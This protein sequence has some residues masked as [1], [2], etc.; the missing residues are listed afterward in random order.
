MGTRKDWDD[1]VARLQR[2]GRPR[3][4]LPD[5]SAHRAVYVH[6]PP[7]SGLQGRARRAD[8][9][10]AVADAA[11]VAAHNAS[12]D[13]S[14]LHAQHP[15]AEG[16]QRTT[17]TPTGVRPAA[18]PAGSVSTRRTARSSSESESPRSSPTKIAATLQHVLV[19][20]AVVVVV[21]FLLLVVVLAIVVC[22]APLPVVSPLRRPAVKVTAARTRSQ[23][24]QRCTAAVE[25]DRPPQLVSRPL[26]VLAL[27]GAAGH[28]QPVEL[29]PRATSITPPPP[30]P[31]A[32]PRH[33]APRP[34]GLRRLSR[35]ARTMR[36]ASTS[37]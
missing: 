35:T 4:N 20:L 37:K 18:G 19:V 3:A 15:A 28:E 12:F 5:P 27:R 13:R 10:R 11:F 34:L 14:V 23:S 7:R 1:A 31:P 17:R 24:A 2:P 6:R 30:R 16:T 29:P 36:N 9:R 25:R 22:H 33:S 32:S 21:L 26:F 8:L